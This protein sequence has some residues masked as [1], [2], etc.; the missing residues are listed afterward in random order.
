MNCCSRRC[1]I[2]DYAHVGDRKRLDELE[3]MHVSINGPGPAKSPRFAKNAAGGSSSATWRYQLGKDPISRRVGP[4]SRVAR[5]D[6]PQRIGDRGGFDSPSHLNV[7]TLALHSHRFCSDQPI[8]TTRGRS[9]EEFSLITIAARLRKPG[10][11][12]KLSCRFISLPRHDGH[13]S[14]LYRTLST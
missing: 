6:E 11:P 12:R 1:V 14:N 10:T 2:A 5:N 9:S 3:V 13:S 4:G 8:G 7:S